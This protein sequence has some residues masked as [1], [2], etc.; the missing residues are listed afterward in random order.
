M[1]SFPPLPKEIQ[2]TNK[3]NNE[4]QQQQK[5]TI[6]KMMVKYASTSFYAVSLDD[7][8]KTITLIKQMKRHASILFFS[9]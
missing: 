9:E 6:A 7:I 3:Q 8:E 5:L 4:K 1:A 2:K